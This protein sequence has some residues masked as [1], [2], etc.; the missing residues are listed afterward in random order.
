MKSKTIV[1]IVIGASSLKVIHCEKQDTDIIIK[2]SVILETS[3]N[4]YLN[5]D[6]LNIGFIEDKLRIFFFENKIKNGKICFTLPDYMV[7][8]RIVNKQ[9]IITNDY[10]SGLIKAK[11]LHELLDDN[12]PNEE[13]LIFDCQVINT[14]KFNTRDENDG[15]TDIMVSYVHNSII[16]SLKQ[17][18]K[19]L[20]MVPAVLEP[21]ANS[22]IRLI[23]MFDI[24]DNYFIIDIG[25]IYTKIMFLSNTTSIDYQIIPS[26]I[27]TIDALISK[28]LQCPPVIASEQRFT[29]GLN[30][31]NPTFNN[32]IND[33]VKDVFA[34][35]LIEHLN[36]I[37]STYG[38]LHFVN[39]FLIAG[40]TW[41]VPGFKEL[42]ENQTLK[43]YSSTAKFE[44]FS[45][46]VSS[47]T[48][49]NEIV[50]SDILANITSYASCVGLSLRGGF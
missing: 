4:L 1:N 14:T 6:S 42:I 16:K 13:D 17:M 34:V 31:D 33:V 36:T 48:F 10:I 37:Q 11:Q 29:F 12:I 50:K 41:N 22:F 43:L 26:G 28:L 2:N 40:G 18:S 38:G 9:Q 47:L 46:F 30:S 19:R 5:K 21:E 24:K 32:I 45:E 15:A 25:E 20:K 7:H 27:Y 3:S 39:K 44:D 35:P 8:T 23:N 49:D